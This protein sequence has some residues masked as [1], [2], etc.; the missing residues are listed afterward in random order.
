MTATPPSDLTKEAI[1]HM[2][3][4]Q[5]PA[6]LPRPAREITV[7]PN[8][9]Y[10]VSGDLPVVRRR[11][12]TSEHGESMVWQTTATVDTPAGTALVTR[13]APEVRRAR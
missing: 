2:P 7:T 13:S 4:E 3:N 6:E 1:D 5:S 12:V 9:P 8:G 11:I 10:L